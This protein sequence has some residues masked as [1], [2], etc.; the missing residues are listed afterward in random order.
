MTRST[1]ALI[2]AATL[3][4]SAGLPSPAR[5][6]SGAV[7]CSLDMA[8]AATLLLPYFE[9]DLR[10]PAKLT[11]L[12]AL[13]NKREQATVVSV[14]LWTDVGIPTFHFNVYLTGW[15]VQTINLRDVFAGAVPRT[16]SA[17]QDPAD[18][19]SPKGSF[20]QD[21]GLAGCGAFLPPGSVPSSLLSSIADA[22]TG[23]F[24][25]TL[26]GCAG[27]AFG[28]GVARGFVTADVVKTCTPRVPGDA[29]Y[30]VAGGAGDAADDNVLA[31]DFMIVDPS[32][33]TAI[34]EQLVRIQAFPGRFANG[35]TTFYGRLLGHS[36]ADDREPL[37]ASWATRYVQRGSFSGGTDFLVWRDPGVTTQPF[38]CGSHPAWYPLG[39][40]STA[41][42]EQEQVQVYQGC[43]V[44]TCPP[45][46]SPTPFPAMANRVSV[47]D[48]GFIPAYGA[49]FPV[50]FDFG[51]LDLLFD[52]ATPFQPTQAWTGTLM[53][54]TSRF[55]VGFGATPLDSACSPLDSTPAYR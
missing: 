24:T 7:A 35:S 4:L 46:V 15:D 34:G 52:G 9:V 31:G 53:T 25:A 5:S 50:P 23:L 1:R 21:V 14:T 16:A 18:Q 40:R 13:E 39:M 10:D 22:H 48:A 36:A 26:S 19:L 29:G 49:P 12:F 3:A 2:G 44:T 28:D 47:A 41:F 45:V 42:D 55:A 51:W 11:T 38:A 6:A 33:N 8:P 20:S 32:G 54:A 30:F 43:G 27:Q 17:A 37:A